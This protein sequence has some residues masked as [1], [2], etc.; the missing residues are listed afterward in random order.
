MV[1]RKPPPVKATPAA[2]SKPAPKVEEPYIRVRPR[3]YILQLEAIAD[4]GGDVVADLT[5]VTFGIPAGELAAWV[6]TELPV[7][8]AKLEEKLNGGPSNG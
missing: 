8:L 1:A 3:R 6:E 7:E 5:P 4:D 2:A